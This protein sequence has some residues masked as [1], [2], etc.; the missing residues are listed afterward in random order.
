MML[1]ML[2]ASGMLLN[3][4]LCCHGRT[5]MM[6]LMP[7]LVGCILLANMLR[8]HG[9]KAMMH[10]PQPLRQLVTKLQYQWGL[11]QPCLKV[12]TVQLTGHGSAGLLRMLCAVHLFTAFRVMS[13]Q[14]A[15]LVQAHRFCFAL[16]MG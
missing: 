7:L 3:N 4:V 12:C 14:L 6:H 1:M 15:F 16:M 8:C 2:L 10:H 5:A 13:V 11:R 9:R